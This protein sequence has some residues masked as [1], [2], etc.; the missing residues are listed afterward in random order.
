MARKTRTK[1]LFEVSV[2]GV[3]A[4]ERNVDDRSSK[5]ECFK[6]DEIFYIHQ[7]WARIQG[8]NF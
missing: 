3:F 8:G 7:C 4:V 2:D 6:T 5:A 1:Q